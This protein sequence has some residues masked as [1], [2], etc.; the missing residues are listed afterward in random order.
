[1]GAG[2]E[3]TPVPSGVAVAQG[4]E[5]PRRQVGPLYPIRFG[6][7]TLD[8]RRKPGPLG[9]MR[10]MPLASR[11]HL[12]APTR[13]HD[14]MVGDIPGGPALSRPFLPGVPTKG[15]LIADA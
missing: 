2:R 13:K 7:A 9:G 10:G 1:M 14:M 5:G 8:W 11:D 4:G 6:S 15:A 3:L 12:F